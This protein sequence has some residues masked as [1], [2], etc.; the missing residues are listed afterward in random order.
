MHM[1]ETAVDEHDGVVFRQY[2]VRMA[3]VA[4]VVL[5]ESQAP[6][7]QIAAYQHLDFGVFAANM[8]H[9]VRAGAPFILFHW[10]L[11]TTHALQTTVSYRYETISDRTITH[12]MRSS[13]LIPVI[14]RTLVETAHLH[15]TY[16]RH[17]DSQ[18]HG[19]RYS[20]D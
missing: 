15:F 10:L 1:P 20:P 13:S 19:G 8:R 11:L 14:P 16:G 2:H 3:R 5:A 4:L 17:D 12:C 7:E 9:R 18:G 6:A